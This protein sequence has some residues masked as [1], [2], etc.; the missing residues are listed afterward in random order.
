MSEAEINDST[1]TAND[2][3]AHPQPSSPRSSVAQ[4]AKVRKPMSD[5]A[6]A[7][8]AKARERAAEVNRQ[9]KEERLRAK[10]AALDPPKEEA[11]RVQQKPPM[12]PGVVLVVEQSESDD[13]NFEGP[14]GVVFVRRKRQKAPERTPH[15]RHMDDLYHRMFP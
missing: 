14:P 6:L 12:D 2:A 7:K 10:V 15:E 1:P 13:D 3:S 5:E 11:Q 4:P 8:L 9:K